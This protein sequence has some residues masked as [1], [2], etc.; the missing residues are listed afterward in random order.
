[1]HTCVFVYVCV[2]VCVYI[3][4]YIYIYILGF[5]VDSCSNIG[6]ILGDYTV[7]FT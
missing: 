5:H 1:M 2:C 3:Y 6:L 4:I 7:P